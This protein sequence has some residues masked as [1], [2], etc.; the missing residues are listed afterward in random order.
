MTDDVALNFTYDRNNHTRSNDG[1][2]SQKLH[3]DNFGLIAQYHFNNAGDALRPYIAG[4]V[5]HGSLTNVEADGHS[6]R[7]QSTYLNAGAG[8][9]YYFLEN[10]YAR[11][12]VEADYKLDNGRFD[13]IPSIGLGVN[14]CLLYTSPS[15]R[16]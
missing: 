8:V 2:G 15:P 7:D 11:A 1:T 3:G 13:Y 5:K 14:F 6:G 10:V 9:K 12:G 4:G 16:D